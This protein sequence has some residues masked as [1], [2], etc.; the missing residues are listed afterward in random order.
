MFATSLADGLQKFLDNKIVGN[1]EL[2]TL[3]PLIGRSAPEV[4]GIQSKV[5]EFVSE[6]KRNLPKTLQELSARLT[7]SLGATLT[8]SVESDGIK[9]LFVWTKN[10]NHEKITISTLSLGNSDIFVG[11]NA[12][13]YLNGDIGLTLNM[14]VGTVKGADGFLPVTFLDDSK[15]NFDVTLKGNPLKFDLSV[16][17][18]S[19]S[20]SLLKV[21]STNDAPSYL[22]M[23]ANMEMGFDKSSQSLKKNSED[24]RI[25][26]KLYVEAAGFG[27]GYINIGVYDKDSN[28]ESW[29]GSDDKGKFKLADLVNTSVRSNLVTEDTT[30]IVAGNPV[31]D[32][33]KVNFDP[34]N[35]TIF[36]KL[37]LVSDGLGSVLRRAQLCASNV[38]VSEALRKIPLIGDNIMAAADC[39]TDLNRFVSISMETINSVLPQ[40]Q[41][42]FMIFWIRTAF[43]RMSAIVLN[44]ARFV[45]RAPH[46]TRCFPVME[47]D[48]SSSMNRRM[49]LNGALNLENDMN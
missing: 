29:S 44:R 16:S 9:A 7:A 46:L 47:V 4:F 36:Q 14:K 19:A 31:L 23:K 5:T 41:N 30:K 3:L 18:A 13:A 38:F 2:K 26:G 43:C 6:L 42:S 49:G 39:L 12:E 34:S 1:A 8:F 45:G 32:M 27:I 28:I 48:I 21:V 37:R 11:G 40:L 24:F 35:N 10:L 33:S 15:V 20:V 25:G 17:T 22:N